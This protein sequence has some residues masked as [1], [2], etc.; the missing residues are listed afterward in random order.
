MKWLVGSLVVLGF[1]YLNI[2]KHGVP[3]VFQG[4]DVSA[5]WNRWALIWSHGSF[6]TGSCGYPQFV[7]TTWAVTYIF[8]GSTEQY[9]AYYTYV[10]LIIVPI[11]PEHGDSRTD[12][13]AI[14]RVAAVRV[15]VVRG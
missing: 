7:P 1:T 6:P 13:L 9:F 8:T 3:N 10:V 14:C 4:S 15:R 12:E 5:S 2:W 11:A